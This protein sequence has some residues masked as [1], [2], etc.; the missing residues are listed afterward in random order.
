MKHVLISAKNMAKG[1]M[2]KIMWLEKHK[3]R[4][5]ICKKVPFYMLKFPR[6]IHFPKKKED[7]L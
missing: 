3:K 1:H 6:I 5:S 2:M 4:R 7:S